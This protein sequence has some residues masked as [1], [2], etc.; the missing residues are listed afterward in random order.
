MRARNSRLFR[1]TLAFLL[2]FSFSMVAASPRAQ[3]KTTE[4]ALNEAQAAIVVDSTGSVLYEKN[5]DDE[6]NMASV[7]KV[8]TA[9]VA[10][11]SETPLDKVCTLSKPHGDRVH[12]GG[13][14]HRQGVH[15]KEKSRLT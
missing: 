13:R 11:E 9:V 2:V 4:P 6:I 10:L 12:H 15:Q 3:A 14:R 7:T 1:L 5:P 8:M